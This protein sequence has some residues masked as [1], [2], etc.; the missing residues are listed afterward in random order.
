MQYRT[1][2][3]T[4][5][6][7]S[8]VC[9]GCWALVGQA[10]DTWG[11]QDRDESRR[12]VRAALDAGITFFDTA[13]VYGRGESEDLLGAALGPRRSEA[14]IASKVSRA[15]LKPGDVTAACDASLRRLQ[16]DCIDLY[17]VHWPDP[18]VPLADTFGALD[19]LK[20]AGKVRAVGVSNFGASYL[21]D[22]LNAGRIEG[23]QVCYSLL[24]RAIEHDVQPICAEHGI[25]I[26]PYSP[27]AQGLLTG[28]FRTADDVPE[29]RARTRLFSTDRPQARHGEPGCE[30]AV[31]AAL[32]RIREICDG[33][34]RPMNEVALAWLLAQESVT[35]VI[36][37][38]RHPA[39]IEANARA[40]DL[41]L[42]ADVLTALD[43]ATQ[44][45][46]DHVGRNIDLWQTDSRADR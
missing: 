38:A 33:L 14:V 46:K 34:G 25:S 1:L 19:A 2:G 43:E 17:Q 6:E 27:L 31:F 40:A 12:T 9:L 16:T 32:D 11:E 4:D 35:T 3:R 8:A 37:G 41:D 26:L 45:V 21:P 18:D 7:V 15:H 42:P 5:I 29:G 24:F 39:Q 36:A 22:A 30:A 44:P 13:E 28:K 10:G 23:N 20:E